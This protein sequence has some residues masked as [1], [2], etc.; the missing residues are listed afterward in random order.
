MMKPGWL[1]ML[2]IKPRFCVTS[3][4]LQRKAVPAMFLLTAYRTNVQ[5]RFDT[6]CRDK[7]NLVFSIV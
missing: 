2:G 6:V 1:D 3:T 5:L 7:D 4:E